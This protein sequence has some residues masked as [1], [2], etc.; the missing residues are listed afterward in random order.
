MEVRRLPIACPIGVPTRVGECQPRFGRS[1]IPDVS[2]PGAILKC[3][4]NTFVEVSHIAR[5]PAATVGKIDDDASPTGK[6][7]VA[8]TES[9]DNCQTACIHIPIS[10][11]GGECIIAIAKVILAKSGVHRQC[12]NGQNSDRY[13]DQNCEPT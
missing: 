10:F 9:F 8:G 6:I 7:T 2:Y 13:G 4:V 3:W 11:A 1:C 5:R 12:E